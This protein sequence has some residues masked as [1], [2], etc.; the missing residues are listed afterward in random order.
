MGQ[1]NLGLRRRRRRRRGDLA[2]DAAAAAA[3]LDGQARLADRARTHGTVGG[4]VRAVL[5]IRRGPVLLFGR[6]AA[7]HRRPSPLRS[8]AAVRPLSDA[9]RRD[10]PAHRGGLRRHLRSAI[11]RGLSGAVPVRRVSA[12]APEIRRLRPIV[13]RRNGHRSGW[14]QVLRSDRLLRRQCLRLRLLQGGYRPRRRARARARP[15][16]RQLSPGDRRQC[17]TPAGDLR[18]RRSIVPHVGHRGGDA[19]GA[20]RALPHPPFPPGALLR[21]LSRLVGRR[22]AGHR[23]PG[24]GARDLHAE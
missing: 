12:P 5:P 9:L 15:R 10:D 20:A 16:A 19:G 21:R 8:D 11:H 14:Q 23:Q 6:R 4:V 24:A 7:G 2:G 22:A 13:G 18:S 3:A 17:A 1:H